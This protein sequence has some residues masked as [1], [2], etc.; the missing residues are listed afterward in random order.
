M[1]V[2]SPQLVYLYTSKLVQNTL[3]KVFDDDRDEG[4][5]WIIGGVSSIDTCVE[6]Y[7]IGPNIVLVW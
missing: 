4:L 2:L 5:T 6:R 3:Y 7:P 1:F